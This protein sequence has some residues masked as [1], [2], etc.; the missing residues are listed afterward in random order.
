MA[1]Y[2]LVLHGLDDS[3]ELVDAARELSETDPE[4]RFVLLVPAAVLQPLDVLLL[5]PCT[6]TQLARQRAGRVRAELMSA[7]VNLVATRLGNS[8][9]A[10]AVEDA[11]RFAAYAAVVVASPPR[12]VL[13]WIRRDLPCRL[14]RRFP[15]ARVMHA[16]EA[17]PFA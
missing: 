15:R 5:P 7:G 1:N 17:A 4:A 9:P 11:L 12:P 8:S 2:L 13:H 10:R 3:S 6:P 14:A 16:L